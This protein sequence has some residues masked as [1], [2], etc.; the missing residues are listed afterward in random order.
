MSGEHTSGVRL[1]EA[2]VALYWKTLC[3]HLQTVAQ[4]SVGFTTQKIKKKRKEKRKHNLNAGS[5]SMPLILL[6]FIK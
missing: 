5:Y 4:V 2:E 6:T 3:K 1:M